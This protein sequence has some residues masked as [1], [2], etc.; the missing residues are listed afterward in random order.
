MGIYKLTNVTDI[1]GKRDIKYN[2]T[3]EIEYVDKIIRQALA[4]S[5]KEPQ[6]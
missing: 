2:S 5:N 3:L 6:N 4:Q 1:I